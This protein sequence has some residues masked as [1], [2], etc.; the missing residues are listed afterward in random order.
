MKVLD[1]TG[2]AKLWNEIKAYV[3]AQ[4]AN[5]ATITIVSINDNLIVREVNDSNNNS[6]L[7]AP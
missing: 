7:A 2:L 6:T 5:N 4:T 3:N 1:L